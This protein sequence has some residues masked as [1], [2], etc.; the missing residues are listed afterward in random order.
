MADSALTMG[1]GDR[2]G[3]KKDEAPSF[4]AVALKVNISGTGAASAGSAVTGNA[5]AVADGGAVEDAGAA[6]EG[7][8][9]IV[10]VEIDEIGTDEVAQMDSTAAA[11]SV[12]K[13]T[14]TTTV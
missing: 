1:D 3:M 12:G 14:D 13:G 2:E 7:K 11:V 5:G 4:T 9:E 10:A 6:M 8:A